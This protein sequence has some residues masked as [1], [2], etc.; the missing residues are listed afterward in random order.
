METL[1][2]L[3][4]L[5]PRPHSSGAATPPRSTEKLLRLMRK[6]V[7]QLLGDFPSLIEAGDRIMVCISGGKDSY[8]MLDVLLEMQKRAPVRYEV[9]AVNVDQGW[10]G[11][12]T[13][14]IERHLQSLG[15][16]Y[17][18]ITEDYSAIVEA[19]LKPGQTPCTLCS[20]FRRGVLYNLATD[21]GCS[22]IALG[23][24]ADDLIE[25]LVM[26]LFY[27]GR[28]ASMPPILHSDDGRNTVIRP[29][30]LVP[31]ALLIEYNQNREFPVV[32]CG[33]P[34]CGLPAQKRQVIKRLLASLEESEPQIKTHMLAALRNVVPDHLMDQ[35]IGRNASKDSKGESI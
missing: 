18:M 3:S 32:R 13:S 5:A 34:S 23:H 9:L 15:V 35:S 17:R 8:A 11:Y 26:N 25:T 22:K 31:E 12:D 7:G 10:P 6:K 21:L 27:S 1:V 30:A 28:L 14:Q 19:M 4:S 16:E 24:H 29:L 33:C 20:R 2:P